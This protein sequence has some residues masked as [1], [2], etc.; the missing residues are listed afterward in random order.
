D[1]YGYGRY[2]G[3]LTS[4]EF[5]RILSASG[6]F[7]GHLIRPADKKEPHRIAWLQC[8][9]SRDVK[10]HSYC[11][12]VCC[13]YAIKQAVIA[14]EHAKEYD[15]DC[16]IF[17][18]DMRTHGKEFEKYYWRARDEH[19]VRFIR[20]RVHSIEPVPGSDDV[21]IRYLDEKGKLHTEVFNMVVLSVGLET[22]Q[23][24]LDLAK[25]LG[26]EVKPDTRFAQT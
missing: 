1:T 20:S 3:V 12:G 14:K 22:S 2:P 23:A 18:M 15:L 19:G 9:G 5:E 24:A 25:T 11:S 6:P 16:A 4:L 21:A 26:V 8:V 7:G 13:M 17:F 10:Q